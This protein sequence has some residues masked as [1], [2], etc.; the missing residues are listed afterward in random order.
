MA[1]H[2]TTRLVDDIDGQSEADT[3]VAFEWQGQRYEI[4]LTQQNADEFSEAIAPYLSASRRIG[5]AGST[6]RRSS[7]PKTSGDI[8]PKAVRAWA[9]D[10]GLEV[11]PR[12]RINAKLLEQYKAAQ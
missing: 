1:K 7:A 5:R 3:T 2:T 11:S 12:G 9:K 6:G 4:D 8:D 10:Q